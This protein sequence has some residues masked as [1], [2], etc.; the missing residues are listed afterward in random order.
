MKGI[1]RALS[2][3][4]LAMVFFC[5]VTPVS[6]LLRAIGRDALKRRIS[7]A[8]RSYWRIRDQHKP[9]PADFFKQSIPK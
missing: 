7:G 4:T 8:E 3:V 5:F 9:A 2:Y 1:Y 6:V